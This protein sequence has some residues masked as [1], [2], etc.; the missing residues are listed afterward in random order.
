MWNMNVLT[1]SR[2]RVHISLVAYNV[3][4]ILHFV[5]LFYISGIFRFIVT[6]FIG[7]VLWLVVLVSSCGS[8]INTILT[9]LDNLLT[10]SSVF[11]NSFWGISRWKMYLTRSVVFLIRL[12]FCY[13]TCFSVGLVLSSFVRRGIGLS[14]ALRSML[15]VGRLMCLIG[16]MPIWVAYPCWKGITLIEWNICLLILR[17][18]GIL[19]FRV[20][21]GTVIIHLWVGGVMGSIEL[22]VLIINMVILVIWCN[23]LIL[24]NRIIVICI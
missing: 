1:I 6:L 18:R 4:S 20:V 21:F 24:I 2:T 13:I 17:L 15:L 5:I 14:D 7:R 22:R 11:N 8:P 23:V 3:L 16:N 9:S 12:V 19:K 10:W